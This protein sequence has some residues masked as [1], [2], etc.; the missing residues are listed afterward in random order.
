MDQ[1]ATD[2]FPLD[3]AQYPL[4][5]IKI[6]SQTNKFTETI[7]DR[8]TPLKNKCLNYLIQPGILL[9]TIRPCYHKRELGLDEYMNE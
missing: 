8:S 1:L 7:K 3:S 4:S 6:N 5:V 2:C 9:S